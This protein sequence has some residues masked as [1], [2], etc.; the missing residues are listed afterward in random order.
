MFRKRDVAIHFVGIGGIGMSGIAEVLLNLGY[1][2][3]G[4]DLR[5]TEVTRRLAALGGRIA[6]G[7]AAA[8]VVKTDVVVISSA[9]RP[10]N[11][12]VAAARAADIPVIPRAEM[13]G[14]LM[15][16]KD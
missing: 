16:V 13:L 9:V 5:D 10:D 4:S 8:N 6:I 1:R 14:E 11:P 12:E 2:V 3:S 7:H 15:R